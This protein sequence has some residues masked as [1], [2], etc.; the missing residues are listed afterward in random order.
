[1]AIAV[2]FLGRRTFVEYITKGVC[3]KPHSRGWLF[4][5]PAAIILHFGSNAINAYLI[6]QTSGFEQI[7]VG[8]LILLWCTRPRLTWMI[9]V[10]IP[11]QAK[12][13]MYFS[14]AVSTLVAEVTLQIAS[15]YYMGYAANYARVQKFFSLGHLNQTPHGNDALLM[16]AGALLWLVVIFFALIACTSAILGLDQRIASLRVK[17]IA[18]TAKRHSK[19]CITELAKVNQHRAQL[20][21]HDLPGGNNSII[22]DFTSL[23]TTLRRC[24]EIWDGLRTYV[25]DDTKE[26]EIVEKKYNSSQKEVE[27][28]RQR[29]HSEVISPTLVSKF[30]SC[31]DTWINK[32]N[33]MCS[34]VERSYN[35]AKSNQSEAETIVFDLISTL[36]SIRENIQKLERDV[37]IT[38]KIYKAEMANT[39]RPSVYEARY[40][41]LLR[42]LEQERNIYRMTSNLLS[43]RNYILSTWRYSELELKR[44]VDCWTNLADARRQEQEDPQGALV[45]RLKNFAI[46]TVLGM[47]GCWIAQWIW[48]IGYIRTMGD[49]Y[50][51]PNLTEMGVVWTVFSAL[52]AFFGA[53]F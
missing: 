48:W 4:T 32:P 27:R 51:P 44:A 21:V 12:E 33:Q 8:K 9:V 23:E 24:T 31:R 15:S 42:N 39:N 17:G 18:R 40:T 52:G 37:R 5:G 50:C 45:K 7:N 16:Y 35:Q 6:H 46:T 1:M 26:Y 11:W 49:S 25:I 53:S 34:E 47:F 2:P 36:H 41:N 30:L 10:L 19:R 22:D 14:V 29:G 20:D 38:W 3:G 13:A 28:A 43:E